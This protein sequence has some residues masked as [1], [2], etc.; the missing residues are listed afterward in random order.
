VTADRGMY[1]DLDPAG[2]GSTI[3]PIRG[4]TETARRQAAAR[5]V[6]SRLMLA[7][8]PGDLPA[9]AR[10]RAEIY[11]VLGLPPGGAGHA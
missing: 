1:Y 8:H 11:D 10:A 5:Q 7:A 3:T 4:A 9:A 2:R 6:I